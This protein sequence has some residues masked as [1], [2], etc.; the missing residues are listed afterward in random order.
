MG[1]DYRQSGRLRFHYAKWAMRFGPALFAAAN[2]G[3]F[4]NNAAAAATA[5][6]PDSINLNDANIGD[7]LHQYK[8]VNWLG[9]AGNPELKQ[10]YRLADF[11]FL[12]TLGLNAA[13][14]GLTIDTK[15]NSFPYMPILLLEGS[16]YIGNGSLHI[17]AAASEAGYNSGAP[18][19]P[20][21]PPQAIGFASTVT[22]RN[23]FIQTGGSVAIE[24]HD[25]AIAV[26]GGNFYGI[27]GGSFAVRT[28]DT[29]TG[30][31]LA[32]SDPTS[33]NHNGADILFRQTGGYIDF[34]ARD[35]SIGLLSNQSAAISGGNLQIYAADQAQGIMLVDN[36]TEFR[37][38]GG[39]IFIMAE[40]DS[41]GLTTAK[42]QIEGGHLS[43]QSN[44]TAKAVYITSG[45]HEDGTPTQGEFLFKSGI[46]EIAGQTAAGEEAH[47]YAVYGDD[48]SRACFGKDSLLR[49]VI[50]TDF[51]DKGAITGI[52]SFGSVQIEPQARLDIA[53]II[54][55]NSYKLTSARPIALNFLESRTTPV[56]GEFT[57]TNSAARQKLFYN[58]EIGL[59]DDKQNYQLRLLP[60]SRNSA[61]NSQTE[62]QALRVSD[63]VHGNNSRAAAAMEGSLRNYHTD[64]A[65]K[66]TYYTL[67]TLYDALYNSNLGEEENIN[68]RL[69]SLSPHQSTRLPALALTVQ[70]HFADDLRRAITQFSTASAANN[71]IIA[72][73]AAASSSEDS[74]ALWLKPAG[75]HDIYRAQNRSFARLSADYGG[76]NFGGTAHYGNFALGIGG[77][78]VSG[79]L[80]GGQNYHANM[81]YFLF[82]GALAYARPAR[83]N[84]RPVMDINF[85]Y[86]AGRFQHYRRDSFAAVNRATINQNSFMVSAVISHY[87]RAKYYKLQFAPQ[88]GLDY[89]YIHQSAY[90]E[91]GGL[92]PL[93]VKSAAFNALRPKIGG[94]V[95]WNST[96]RLRLMAYTYYR[97]DLLD[98][99]INLDTELR[100]I[101]AAAWTSKGENSSRSSVSSGMEF[102]Y[103]W[104]ENSVVSS[105]YDLSMRRHR[106]AQ[107]FSIRVKIAF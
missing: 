16:L 64:K 97:Y 91:K 93:H 105:A 39:S 88:F 35:S 56:K 90:S 103:H 75:S 27:Q 95:L 77:G 67:K 100:H 9:Y 38:Q 19:F 12:D 57:L 78:F 20:E 98:T 101:A 53:D 5:I 99:N 23:D 73:Q 44:N 54:A 47:D 72:E 55:V 82:G 8:G 106:T 15:Q 80:H 61:G 22:G 24:A 102:S 89:A 76:F 34:A 94:A 65:E 52:L 104:R 21:M 26:S 71:E 59:S 2:I 51:A 58:Y 86:G 40:N 17:I 30:V 41:V 49:P 25:N 36:D 46:M 33:G 69:Q 96:H 10:N 85:S 92:L 83:G 81:R 3:G 28:Q 74:P 29:A 32:Y 7:Y 79:R 87:Y 60:K 107:N 70:E 45:R 48:G 1:K 31:S 42:L 43:L 11:I 37:Q 18:L 63:I 84:F 14:T 66:T 13:N 62:S 50:K 6:R 4:C 68:S